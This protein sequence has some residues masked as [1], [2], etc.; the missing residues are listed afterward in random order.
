MFPLAFLKV[1]HE[2]LAI[3]IMLMCL[4]SQERVGQ[5]SGTFG[6]L[7]FR[8]DRFQAGSYM[9]GYGDVMMGDIGST[10]DSLSMT[11]AADRDPA[12]PNG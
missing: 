11:N 5:K 9:D 12:Y 10:R 3:V 2:C 7:S 4:P 6:R 8:G 1:T